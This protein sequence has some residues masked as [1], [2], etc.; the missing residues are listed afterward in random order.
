MQLVLSNQSLRIASH[1]TLLHLLINVSSIW[2]PQA[3]ERKNIPDCVQVRKNVLVLIN[4]TAS[5][6]FWNYNTFR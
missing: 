5:V 6:V 1:R 3:G 2:A 4:F